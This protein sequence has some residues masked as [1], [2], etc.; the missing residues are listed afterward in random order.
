MAYCAKAEHF[1]KEARWFAA[2]YYVLE[3]E[4]VASEGRNHTL[5]GLAR[6]ERN[7]ANHIDN[8]LDN[9]PALKVGRPD[10]PQERARFVFAYV[11]K[12]F[13][14]SQNQIS[15]YWAPLAAAHRT[16]MR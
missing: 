11:S 6:M 1:G 5:S 14:R 9:S 2:L 13:S 15:S 8:H 12:H 3:K 4:D 7:I 16:S 10:T